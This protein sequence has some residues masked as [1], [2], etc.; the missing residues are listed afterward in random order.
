MPLIFNLSGSE[1]RLL[2]AQNFAYPSG[3]PAAGEDVSVVIRDTSTLV[4]LYSSFVG[5]AI[6]TNPVILD[7][8]GNIEFYLD[9]GSYDFLANGARIPFDIVEEGSGAGFYQQ[10]DQTSALATWTIP[11]SF[12]RY[13]SV[14][15]IDSASKVILTDLEY[16]D[17][18]TV[19]ATFAEPTIGKAILQA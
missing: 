1:S 5:S 12:G 9:A 13:P 7:E 17:I 6:V 16:P 8:F 15:L 4:P 10:Y 3:Q 14:T 18:A 2:V 19:V 11:H